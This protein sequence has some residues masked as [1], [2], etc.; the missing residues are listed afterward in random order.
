MSG[1]LASAF[2]PHLGVLI[3]AATG[4][5]IVVIII[6]VSPELRHGGRPIVEDESVQ[7]R[8]EATAT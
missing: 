7:E 6:A 2:T 4:L 1:A 3:P 8:S 5:V